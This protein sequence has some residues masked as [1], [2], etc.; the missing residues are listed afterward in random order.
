[1]GICDLNNKKQLVFFLEIFQILITSSSIN[2]LYYQG[3]FGIYQPIRSN[4]Y[5]P[6]PFRF[7]VSY[8][9]IDFELLLN[10]FTC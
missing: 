7:D 10:I 9:K 1:M 4:I 2:E 5:Y 3:I 6:A 8:Q